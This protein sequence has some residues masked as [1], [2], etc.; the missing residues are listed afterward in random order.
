MVI[1]DIFA[2]REPDTGLIHARNLAEA[3]DDAK[4]IKDFADIEKYF[5]DTACD[6]D[7]IF[8][9]GAGDIYKVGENIVKE[10]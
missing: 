1:T 8:T 10:K 9:M 4:Y 2:A 6:G 5:V 3:I 7:I